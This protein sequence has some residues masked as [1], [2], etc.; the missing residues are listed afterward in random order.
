MFCSHDH[1]ALFLIVAFHSD[2]VV[3]CLTPCFCVCVFSVKEK[4]VRVICAPGF[5]LVG[6]PFLSL[7]SCEIISCEVTQ[8]V[9]CVIVAS[10]QQHMIHTSLCCSA[11]TKTEQSLLV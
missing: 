2:S 1:F 6:Q 5:V 7:V 8:F 4:V 10:Y 3:S 11:V 9:V